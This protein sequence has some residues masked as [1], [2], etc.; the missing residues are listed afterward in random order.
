MSHMKRNIVAFSG[1]HGT[2]KTTAA[3]QLAADLK[4]SEHKEVGFVAETARKCPYP[5]VSQTDAKPSREAQL[6]IFTA[7]MQA[8]ME[9]SRI[10]PVVVS[11]RTVV[12]SIAYT[13]ALGFHDLAHALFQVA[14]HYVYDAY[15][16][17]RLMRIP[18]DGPDLL[19][20]DGVR[21][22]DLDFRV[23]VEMALISAYNDL[24]VRVIQ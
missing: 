3:Y 1:T 7:Q 12:D 11:D 14:R 15:M 2:G 5:C 6:W 18:T 17:V 24:G 10:Y 19:V 22:M 23:E 4:R 21:S 20:D 13:S 9:A 16:C 8:E